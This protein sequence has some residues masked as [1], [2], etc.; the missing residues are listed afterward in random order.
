MKRSLA[1]T[2]TIVLGTIFGSGGS[3]IVIGNFAPTTRCSKND[4]QIVADIGQ[5]RFSPI[6][7]LDKLA[8]ENSVQAVFLNESSYGILDPKE[9]NTLQF[10]GY[11]EQ[12]KSRYVVGEN[13]D[14]IAMAFSNPTDKEWSFLTFRLHSHLRVEARPFIQTFDEVDQF[15]NDDTSV[16]KSIVLDHDDNGDIEYFCIGVKMRKTGIYG[17]TITKLGS[18]T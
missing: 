3:N 4:P 15:I 9:S 11:N 5:D 10:L 17:I 6:N 8:R 18:R 7:K 16:Y 2:N 14:N 13:H 12:I 1:H